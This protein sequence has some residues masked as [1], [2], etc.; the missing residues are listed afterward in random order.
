M[1][2]EHEAAKIGYVVIPGKDWEELVTRRQNDTVG[3][4]YRRRR[5]AG[6]PTVLPDSDQ[7]PGR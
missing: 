3:A 2:L 7:P 6:L 1:E 4:W 5:A